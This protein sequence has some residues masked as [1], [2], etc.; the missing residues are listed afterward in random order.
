MLLL[1]QSVVDE[2]Y[3]SL[4]KLVEKAIAVI[5]LNQNIDAAM[6]FCSF[7]LTLDT[8]HQAWCGKSSNVS[9]TS[10]YKWLLETAK[11]GAMKL[12]IR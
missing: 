3:I 2:C 7:S 9:K 6:N 5:L 11:F 4:G 8:G 12:L 1:M 10:L